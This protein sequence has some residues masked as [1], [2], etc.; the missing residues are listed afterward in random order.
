MGEE[1]VLIKKAVSPV[2]LSNMTDG[3]FRGALTLSMGVRNRPYKSSHTNIK[4]LA[5]IVGRFPHRLLIC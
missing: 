1:E 3:R 2:P 5:A 4:M